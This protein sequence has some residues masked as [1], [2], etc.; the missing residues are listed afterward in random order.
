ML[1]GASQMK[2]RGQAVTNKTTSTV[3]Q[4]WYFLT[5]FSKLQRIKDE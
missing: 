4:V 5:D 1:G 3:F 2:G